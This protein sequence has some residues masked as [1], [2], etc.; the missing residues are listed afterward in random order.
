[1]TTLDYITKKYKLN[2]ARDFYVEIPN[3]NR[4]G[5]ADLFA[6]LNFNLGAEIGVEKGIYSEIL[7]KANPNLL[8]YCV[9]PWSSGVYEPGISGVDQ[10][11]EKYDERYRET[12]KRLNPYRVQIMRDESLGA[13]RHI[14]DNSLD[15]VYI[16]GNHDLPHVIADLDAWKQKVKVG[17]IIS[18]HDY[19]PY[20]YD[21][22][23]H[24]KWAV[25]TYVRCYRCEV[26]PLFLV[27]TY[28]YH[29]GFLRDKYR[30]WFWIK[31]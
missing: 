11:Q 20:P 16:D 9:D 4:D 26:T 13:A 15:F 10:E 18:G 14:P 25:D 7:C 6:E 21:K 28:E 8:L 27:G 3:M 22:K 31:K 17:G 1:M 2:F 12:I 29:E 30:S 23:N 5:L 24:V 19:A